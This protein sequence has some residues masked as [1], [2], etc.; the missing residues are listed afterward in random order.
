MKNLI[1]SIKHSKTLQHIIRMVLDPVNY[2]LKKKNRIVLY[3]NWGFRDNV[4][5]LYKYLIDNNYN[6][7]NEIIC[8]SNDFYDIDKNEIKNVSFKKSGFSTLHYYLSSKYFFYCFGGIP[9]KPGKNQVVF[10]LWH[11]MP[12]KKI[13]LLDGDNN[14]RKLDYFTHILSYSSFFTPIIAQSFG[15]SEDKVVTSNAPRNEPFIG[16]NEIQEVE[17]KRTIAWLPT[18]RKSSKLSSKNGNSDNILPLIADE[19]QLAKLDRVAKANDTNI[20]IKLHPLQDVTE[21]KAEYSNIIFVDEQ[22]L[23]KR[24]Q[25]LYEFLATMDALITDFSSISV[26]YLLLNRPIYYILD[27][28]ESYQNSRGLNYTI[29]DFLAG[30]EVNTFEELCDIFEDESDRF[31]DLRLRKLKEFYDYTDSGSKRILEIAGVKK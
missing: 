11:G 29:D 12:W 25:G 23:S 14:G 13:G 20:F 10:N 5:Y 16:N 8:I 22:W 15:V 28:K 9:V 2:L 27:D 3:S 26:D 18:Y 24:K 30:A 6:E 21:I 4:A 31:S 7:N 17:D 1:D 19:N